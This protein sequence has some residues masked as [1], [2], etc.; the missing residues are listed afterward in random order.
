[1]EKKLLILNPFAER[2]RARLEPQFPEVTFHSALDPNEASDII[3]ETHILFAIGH[4]FGDDFIKDASELEWIQSLISGTDTLV[5]LKTLKKEVLITS[6]RGIHGPQMSEMAFLHMLNL[7]RG[8]PRMLRNQDQ[9]VW[10]RW[11]QSLLYQKTVGILGIGVIA[12]ELARKCKAF[13]MTV[14]GISSTVRE[15]EGIDRFFRREQLPE[16]AAMVDF[17]IILV[18]YSPE[19]DKIVNEK[20]ISAMKPSAYLINLA[21][22]GV[23]DEDALIEALKAGKIAGAGLDVYSEEPLPENHPFW[24]MKNVMMTPKLGGMSDIYP[25]QVMPILEKNLRYFLDGNRHKMINIV[26]RRRK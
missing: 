6:G 18:P 4:A 16:A 7:A 2:Y 21:R 12:E 11:P 9:R 8:Y 15:V 19:T 25:E 3:K 14:Y 13:N 5:A 1:M 26:E 22:G 24:G 10:E 17:L 20:V 23:L